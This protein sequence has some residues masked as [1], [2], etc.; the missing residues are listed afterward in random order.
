MR[1]HRLRR[2]QL[3]AAGLD[4]VWAFFSDPGN[5]GALTPPEM[6]FRITSPPESSMTPGQILSYRIR[7]L[8]GVWVDWV[9]EITHLEVG[10]LFV[11]EQRA[12]PY[13]F[14]HHRHRFEEKDGGVRVIDEVHYALP[15][16]PV[17]ELAHVID[18]RS[19]LGR[20]FDHRAAALAERF[21]AP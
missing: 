12:G 17:G 10:R 5:L 6:A 11:D 2:E 4:E 7:L 8:R 20:I 9:T 3:V 19:R 18:V 1:L 13:R 16:G 14:W 15:L 21:R